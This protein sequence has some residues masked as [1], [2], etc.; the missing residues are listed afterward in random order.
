MTNAHWI[1][2]HF[3][4]VLKIQ[5]QTKSE[6]NEVSKMKNITAESD[7]CS[8]NI[9]D[10]QATSKTDSIYTEGNPGTHARNHQNDIRKNENKF[11]DEDHSKLETETKKENSTMDILG[12]CI[13]NTRGI[14]MHQQIR[15]VED[16]NATDLFVVC[17]QRVC[18]K[19]EKNVF[20]WP[21]AIK[22][23]CWY[24]HDK[25]LA[26]IP[27]Q[28]KIKGSSDSFEVDAV[29]GFEQTLTFH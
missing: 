9:S 23:I 1:P 11:S 13:G 25:I 16:G 15:Y 24:K 10:T 7:T 20:Y 2:N 19:L 6:Y 17:M 22:D 8:N 29:E 18:R 3:V 28:K 21:K 26:I 14:R 27:E 5:Q 12:N 4:P